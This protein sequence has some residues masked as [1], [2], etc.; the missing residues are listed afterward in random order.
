MSQVDPGGPIKHLGLKVRSCLIEFPGRNCRGMTMI[1]HCALANS[2]ELRQRSAIF[3]TQRH[4]QGFLTCLGK[5][6]MGPSIRPSGTPPSDAGPRAQTAYKINHYTFGSTLMKKLRGCRG[7]S[8]VSYQQF[9][10]RVHH[11]KVLLSRYKPKH[12]RDRFG[13]LEDS[14]GW[15][16]GQKERL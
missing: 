4:N 15:G 11:P 7:T 10:R 3:D 14:R 1:F 8:Q 13:R 9:F 5:N 6:R 2:R 12:V 16:A